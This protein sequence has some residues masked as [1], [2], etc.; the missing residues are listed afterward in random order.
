MS[1]LQSEDEK[2][3]LSLIFQLRHGANGFLGA[4]AVFHVALGYKHDNENV[5]VKTKVAVLEMIRRHQRDTSGA[6]VTIHTIE[7]KEVINS[8]IFSPFILSKRKRL[9]KEEKR[10]KH[11]DN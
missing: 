10:L 7:K 11:L 5:N 9:V 1:L 4:N 6:R 3:F 2:L 8:S